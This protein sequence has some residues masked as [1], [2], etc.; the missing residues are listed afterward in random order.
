M[1]QNQRNQFHLKLIVMR[2]VQ[3]HVQLRGLASGDN[4][5]PLSIVEGT[6]VVN[7]RFQIVL[8]TV[9]LL[10]AASGNVLLAQTAPAAAPQPGAASQMIESNTRRILDTL[11]ARRAEFTRDRTALRAFVA[12]ELDA[13]FDRA[14]SAR[15]VLGRHARGADA[16]DIAL[17]ADALTDGLL[18]RYGSALLDF[19]TRLDVRIGAETEL[20]RNMGVRVSSQLL[21]GSGEPVALDYLLRQNQGQWKVFDVMIEGISMVQTFRQQFDAELQRKSIR[22]LAEELRAGELQAGAE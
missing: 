18:Q 17:F 5:R 14:Y 4:V 8:F 22:E 6:P 13:I 21:R 3:L 19:N 20:P 2:R 15:M 9:L 16:A 7:R 12:A 11:D 10:C 1:G